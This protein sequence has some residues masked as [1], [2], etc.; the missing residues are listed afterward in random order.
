MPLQVKFAISFQPLKFAALSFSLYSLTGNTALLKTI[1]LCITNSK[2]LYDSNKL[3]IYSFTY[4]FVNFKATTNSLH[5]ISVN[6]N[7]T[8]LCLVDQHIEIRFLQVLQEN[9]QM[10]YYN[11]HYRKPLSFQ[12]TTVFVRLIWGCSIISRPHS[13]HMVHIH[14]WPNYHARVRTIE[15]V[16]GENWVDHLALDDI[17]THD[18]CRCRRY[19]AELSPFY[20]R[21]EKIICTPI[22]KYKKFKKNQV[23]MF[24][25]KNLKPRNLEKNGK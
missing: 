23:F 13:T 2:K 7:R 4:Q 16:L 18:R 20:N 21:V 22:I 24:N 10:F 1:L 19:T 17:I 5:S 8:R 6:Y 25:I 11:F 15:I 12:N 3:E 9:Q 14:K